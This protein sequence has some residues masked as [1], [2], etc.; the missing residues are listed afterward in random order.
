MSVNGKLANISNIGDDMHKKYENIPQIVSKNQNKINE[1]QRQIDLASEITLEQIKNVEE[2]INDWTT[3]NDHQQ[4]QTLQQQNVVDRSNLQ[5]VK[6]S[7]RK[8]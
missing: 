4:S 8:L 5:E 1:T 7:K 2:K 6:G 3:E